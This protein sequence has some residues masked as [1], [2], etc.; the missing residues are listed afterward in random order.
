M[1]ALQGW[2]N[3]PATNHGLIIKDY[4]KATD[5][6]DFRSRE[7]SKASQRPKL[8]VSYNAG[9]TPINTA[10]DVDAGSNQTINISSLALL[11]GTVKDDGNPNPPHL[12]TTLWSTVSGPGNVL[13]GQ[14]TATQTSAQFDT[15]GSLRAATGGRRWRTAGAGRAD[16]RRATSC[17]LTR[18]RWSAAGDDQQI[19]IDAAA[20][21]AASVTDDGLPA[22]PGAVT[23]LW[24]VVSGPGTVTFTDETALATDAQFDTAGSYVLQLAADDGELQAQDELTV[25]VRPQVVNQPPLVTAGDDQLIVMGAA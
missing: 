3:D 12:V 5:G 6:L 22:A 14:A 11:D 4:N 19:D 9:G 24:T 23:T 8:S 15:A 16:R 21:L 1:A 20:T 13:F 17:W 10:P 2:I 7:T 18:R 25:V